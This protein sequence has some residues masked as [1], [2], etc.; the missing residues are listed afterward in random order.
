MP[1]HVT[2]PVFNIDIVGPLEKDVRAEQPLTGKPVREIPYQKKRVPEKDFEK[3]QPKTLWGEGEDIEL[4]EV[5]K[6]PGKD[7]QKGDGNASARDS[8]TDSS[9]ETGVLPEGENGLPSEKKPFLFDKETIEK[10]AR[11]EPSKGTGE[12]KGLTFQA[13][14]LKH[15]GYMRMLK[16]KIEHAWKYPG[17]AAARGI[18]G[19]LYIAFTIRK[20]GSIR[21][22]K[23]IRT[24][25]H[26]DLDE[27]ALKAL[28]DAAP[29]WPLPDDWQGDTL[30]IT[31]HFI[32]FFGSAYVL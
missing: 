15:R 7:N 26:R 29:F 1:T 20:D 22:S 17:E 2:T 31:G 3:T 18:S 19:D 23:L 12:K 14:E 16:D 4:Q 28:E 6:R 8:E 24:S 30:T 27:A 10:Y 32:Y 9:V 21:E 11:K 13:P 5:K 25:G